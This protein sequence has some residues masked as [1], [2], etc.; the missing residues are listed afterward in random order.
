MHRF[1]P[2]LMNHLDQ[3]LELANFSSRVEEEYLQ[4][5]ECLEEMRQRCCQLDCDLRKT[6]QQLRQSESECS[7]LQ[8]KLKHAR[9][10]VEVEMK[11]RRWAEAELEK[12]ECKLQLIYKFLMEDPQ[13]SPRTEDQHADLA[14]VEKLCFN[15]SS[16]LP[17]K[18]GMC[19]VEEPDT[20]IL[21][22][23]NFDH[24][25]KEVDVGMIRSVKSKNRVRFSLAPLVRPAVAA[26]HSQ[27]SRTF[28]N[29]MKELPL[30]TL[31]SRAIG[32]RRSLAHSLSPNAIAPNCQSQLNSS[33]STHS[34]LTSVWNSTDESGGQNSHVGCKAIGSTSG[35]TIGAF[36]HSSGMLPLQQHQF[37]SKMVIRLHWCVICK[38]RLCFGRMALKC[39]SCQ[40][41]IHPECKEHCP[42][43]C[44]PGA[45]SRVKEGILADFAPSKPPR[46]PPIV[47][48]C[49]AQIEKRG[50]REA[51]L[52]R[53]PGAESLVREWK[54]K[55]L[56]SQEALPSLDLVA[57]VHVIC[58]ILK[59]FLR[60]LKEPLVT[61]CLHSA[62]LQAAEI[63]D[64]PACHTE[65]CQVVMKLPVTNR[66]TLAFLML[67]LRRVMQSPDCQMD[68]H[69]LARIFGPLL[70]GHSTP[71]PSPLAIMEGTPRQYLVISRLLT[72]PLKF[73]KHFIEEEQENLVPSLQQSIVMNE[74]EASA[75][76]MCPGNGCFPKKLHN[77]IGTTLPPLNVPHA[78]KMGRFLPLPK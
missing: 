46:V 45:H 28:T 25:D 63:L 76:Q 2:L 77:C 9:N 64:E 34:E 15:H 18:Q 31:K 69:N 48:R 57:D 38:S 71:S 10:Q 42:S 21:S 41:L 70:V 33:I 6:R 40:L 17:R 68:H 4:I 72:L 58:G 49:V 8:V 43:Q 50:L 67:H 66:D 55:L 24:S 12:Q 11:K 62:F 16:P 14:I 36:T 61:F 20:S 59:D 56:S 54:Y 13:I 74:Q 35:G 39:C 47:V 37:A 23:I 19:A 30:M 26:K 60:N 7:V 29:S 65:L 3:L 51:G 75:I 22:D 27:S 44:V 78:K 53:V 52:Y 5:A 73:W 1:G 32:G